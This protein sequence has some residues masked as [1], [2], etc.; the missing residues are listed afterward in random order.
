MVVISSC[1][2]F[3]YYL[4]IVNHVENLKLFTARDR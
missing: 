3:E 2:F 1:I 4:I